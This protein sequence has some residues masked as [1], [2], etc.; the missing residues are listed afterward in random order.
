M[1]IGQI[2]VRGI[3]VCMGRE[4]VWKA[5]IVTLVDRGKWY[6]AIHGKRY[7]IPVC[8]VRVTNDFR[9]VGGQREIILLTFN[10]FARTSAKAQSV[11]GSVYPRSSRRMYLCICEGQLE[12][13]R[14]E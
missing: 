1:N 11:L 2:R 6:Q 7:S 8:N 13:A 9:F 3:Q 5:V 10:D 12:N 14:G 4:R